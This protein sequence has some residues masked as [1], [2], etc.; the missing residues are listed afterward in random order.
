MY[1][2]LDNDSHIFLLLSFACS[3][4]VLL[5]SKV[6]PFFLRFLY[7]FSV[8]YYNDVYTRYMYVVCMNVYLC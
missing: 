8:F 5:A 3:L 4:I 2:Y 1:K 7:W 6:Y